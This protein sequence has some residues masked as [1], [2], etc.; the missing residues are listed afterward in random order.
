MNK[1]IILVC[2]IGFI[3]SSGCLSIDNNQNKNLND[4]SNTPT[5]G[6]TFSQY[7]NGSAKITLVNKDSDIENINIIYNN[8]I[9]GELTDLGDSVIVKKSGNY[10][11]VVFYMDEEYIVNKYEV[12]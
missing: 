1:T 11:V 2:L 12:K 4:R 9:I 7:D 3:L 10:S 6:T 8:D 5:I